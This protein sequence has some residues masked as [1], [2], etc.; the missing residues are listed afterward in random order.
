MKNALLKLADGYDFSITNGL[1]LDMQLKR[2]KRLKKHIFFFLLILL[3]ALMA[4]F[5]QIMKPFMFI[6]PVQTTQLDNLNLDDYDNLMI[7]A[8]PDDEFIFGGGHLLEGKYLVVCVTRG[9]DSIRSSEF[10]T[11]MN[12][13]AD[14]G[15]ILN[16]PDKIS[17]IRSKWIFHK[18]AIQKDLETIINYKKWNT[19]V[20]H[21]SEGEYGHNQ[22]ILLHG[23][24]DKACDKCGTK[25][26]LYYFGKYYTK[27]SIPKDLEKID[28][29]LSDKKYEIKGIYKS[30]AKTVDK[31]S[32][33][34]P[35]EN[36]IKA[37]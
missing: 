8:H 18:K 11:M 21:N 13:T 28:S 36:F 3:I 14:K 10:A 5:Y 22:H 34:F 20:T 32:H 31:L 6:K 2:I 1:P 7:V 29:K 17:Q 12:A 15:L 35:Y 16:Y 30:Q 37:E 9:Y 33:M 25:D 26:N 24:V 4:Y 27:S 23:I 19:I